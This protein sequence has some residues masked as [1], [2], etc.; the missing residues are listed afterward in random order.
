MREIGD[1][2]GDRPGVVAIGTL[3]G[4]AGVDI[5]E[6]EPAWNGWPRDRNRRGLAPLEGARHEDGKPRRQQEIAAP[7][8]RR[9]HTGLTACVAGPK[10]VRVAR[11]IS[12]LISA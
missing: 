5:L 9:A 11:A 12:A 4:L 6:L 7:P 10:C 1:S 8:Q 3:E 2:I